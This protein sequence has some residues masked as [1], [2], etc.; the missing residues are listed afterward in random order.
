MPGT[1]FYSDPIDRLH[2][3]QLQFL[4][5]QQFRKPST[6]TTKQK[7][8]RLAERE[9]MD[10]AN[11]LGYRVA[12]TTHKSPFDLWIEGVKVEVKASTWHKT[13]ERRGSRYQAN[14][15]N[16]QFDILIFDCINGSHHFHIIPMAEIIPR[17]HLAV[18][19]FNP[20]DSD[21]QWVQF[22]DKWYF[23]AQAVDQVNHIWQPPLFQL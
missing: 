2:N 16:Y 19:S 9:I 21:G 23:L 14:I 12:T 4:K 13:N 1:W 10:L 11:G 3:E 8:D 17:R 5:A 18:W 6:S 20:A 7:I 15:R 22:L